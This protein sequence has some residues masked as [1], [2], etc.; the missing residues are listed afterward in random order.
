MIIHFGRNPVRGGRPARD[1]SVSRSVAFND[2]VF[3]HMVISV[4]RFR[5]LMGFRVRKTAAV[6]RVYR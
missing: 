5:A 3:V 4:G 1:S 6:I 2:G